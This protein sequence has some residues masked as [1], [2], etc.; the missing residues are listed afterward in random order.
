MQKLKPAGNF[1]CE[2]VPQYG[3]RF[4]KVTEKPEEYPREGASELLMTNAKC[5]MF[6][7]SCF[8]FLS[9]LKITHIVRLFVQIGLVTN[10]LDCRGKK[11]VEKC[12]DLF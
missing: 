12:L 7:L 10:T 1:K 11:V 5:E 9:T 6:S 2:I 4:E 3:N 8:V